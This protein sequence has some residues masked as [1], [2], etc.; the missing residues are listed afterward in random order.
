MTRKPPL[1]FT[2]KAGFFTEDFAGSCRL[3]FHEASHQPQNKNKPRNRK[4]A[5]LRSSD[6]KFY[7]VADDHLEDKLIPAEQIEAQGP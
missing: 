3:S 6:G 1:R 4:M 5:I 2:G 7:E